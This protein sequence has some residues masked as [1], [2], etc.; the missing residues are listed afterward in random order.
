MNVLLNGAIAR[1]GMKILSERFG[2]RISLRHMTDED[3]QAVRVE[4]LA[5]AEFMV[6]VDYGVHMPPA[7]NLALLQ[8][9]ASGLDAVD[10]DTLPPQTTVCNVYE[11]E[12]A[13]AEY[14]F[15]GMLE[16]VVG[17]ARRN[18]AFKGGDWTGTPSTGG[19]TR[20]E[21]AGMTLGCLG[22]G[23]IGRAIAKRAKAFDMKVMALTRSPRALDPEPDFM[24]GYD[25]LRQVLSEAD[26]FVI[27]CP[28][29]DD[30][31]GMIGA[32]ELAAMQ[33]SAVIINVAR[34]HIADEDALYNALRDGTVAGGILDTWYHYPSAAEPDIRP[35]RQP[36]HE[37]ENVL[38]TPHISGWS[39]GQQIRR[40][41]KTG[42][43]LEAL[44]TGSDLINVIWL[45]K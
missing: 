11:H 41:D 43:N 38:M 23:N 5:W 4:N 35:S 1:R 25:D 36:F 28:L 22:Y 31:R 45:G 6:S 7:P 27:C 19:E 32:G 15:N 24:G 26:F 34:G 42:D 16:W 17:L 10:V 44:L 20:G 18:A 8:V 14:T 12:V 37:L 13:I 40:W 2:D 30:T 3:S 9:P 39:E 29:T 21:L 33:S